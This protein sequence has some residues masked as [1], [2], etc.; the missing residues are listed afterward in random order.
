M[1]PYWTTSI[2][3]VASKT[4]AREKPT[5]RRISRVGKAMYSRMPK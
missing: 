4:Q 5:S 2:A 1:V 3:A